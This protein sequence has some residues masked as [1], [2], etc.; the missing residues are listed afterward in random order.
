MRDE[1][2]PGPTTSSAATSDT[3]G[4]WQ[5]RAREAHAVAVLM[6]DPGARASMLDLSAMY[7]ALACRAAERHARMGARFG[8]RLGTAGAG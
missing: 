5:G 7:L 4:H 1:N 3:A 6:L 2:R 8:M